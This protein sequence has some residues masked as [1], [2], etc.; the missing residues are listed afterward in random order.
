MPCRRKSLRRSR[1]ST[2]RAY[3]AP[4]TATE[5]STGRV[6]D[7]GLRGE[8]KEARTAAFEGCGRRPGADVGAQKTE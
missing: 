2:A 7:A 3:V 8:G 1:G 4:L 6:T 5:M